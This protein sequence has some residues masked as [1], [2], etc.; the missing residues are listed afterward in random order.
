MPSSL[1]SSCFR[2]VHTHTQ[3]SAMSPAGW[4]MS[5]VSTWPHLSLRR[6]SSQRPSSNTH[7]TDVASYWPASTPAFGRLRASAS[8][9]VGK[10]QGKRVALTCSIKNNHRWMIAFSNKDFFFSIG[11]FERKRLRAAPQRC[12]KDVCRKSKIDNSFSRLCSFSAGA[13]LYVLSW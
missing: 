8:A 7:N 13:S 1:H 5:N 4:L 2:S 3:S 12:V 9:C 10:S 6:S 11:D